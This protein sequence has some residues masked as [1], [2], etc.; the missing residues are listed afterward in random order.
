MNTKTEMTAETLIGFG[1]GRRTA[2]AKV[3]KP[4]QKDG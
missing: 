4:T 2:T 1:N 3:G